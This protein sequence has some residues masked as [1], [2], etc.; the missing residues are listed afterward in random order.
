MSFPCTKC[1]LCCQ[2]IREAKKTSIHA[3]R[4][5]RKPEIEMMV[6]HDESG[7]CQ[8]YD[9]GTSTCRIYEHRPLICRVEGMAKALK[10]STEKAYR[11]QAKHCNKLIE[12]NGYDDIF[13]VRIPDLPK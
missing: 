9:S 5:L 13:I 2:D 6:T 1:G 10:I 4:I 8:H 12:A 11:T 7:K 3:A